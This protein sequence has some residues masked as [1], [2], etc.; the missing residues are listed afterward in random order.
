MRRDVGL[1][2]VPSSEKNDDSNHGCFGE[3]WSVEKS[4]SS[5]VEIIANFARLQKRVGFGFRVERN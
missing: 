2:R 3:A 4:Y 1:I 5:S